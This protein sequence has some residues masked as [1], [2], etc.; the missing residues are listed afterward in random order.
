MKQVNIK[1]LAPDKVTSMALRKILMLGLAAFVC[2]LSVG[3][4]FP[5]HTDKTAASNLA[6]SPFF[7]VN[8]QACSGQLCFPTT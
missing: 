2:Y 8:A 4:N 1:K 3:M 5:E 7:Y 6:T